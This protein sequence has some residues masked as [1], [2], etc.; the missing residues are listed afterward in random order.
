[1]GATEI[2]A[3]ISALCAVAVA[4]I[5]FLGKKKVIKKADDLTELVGSIGEA[6]DSLKPLLT[7]DVKKQLTGTIK[8]N[9]TAKN[10]NG[11]LDAILKKKGLNQ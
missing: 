2:V 4:V 9:A 1:M 6:V 10:V 3:I 7:A 8:G 11:L 5:Q